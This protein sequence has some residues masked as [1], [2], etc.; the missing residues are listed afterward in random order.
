MLKTGHYK[1]YSDG[2]VFNG[3][4]QAG[5]GWVIY[6]ADGTD[7]VRRGSRRITE[8]SRATTT[9]TEICAATAALNAIGGGSTITLHV[10]DAELYTVLRYHALLN[11]RIERNIGKPEL[12]SGYTALFNAVNRHAEVIAVKTDAEFCPRLLLAHHLAREGAFALPRPG[13]P[14]PR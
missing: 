2:S 11:E 13:A 9:L 12:Q 3:G 7:P 6:E 14:A 5:A 4:C 8:S 10:D 1:A